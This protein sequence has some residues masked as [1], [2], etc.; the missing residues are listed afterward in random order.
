MFKAPKWRKLVWAGNDTHLCVEYPGPFQ[1]VHNPGHTCEAHLLRGFTQKYIPDD[2]G[3][4]TL[5]LQ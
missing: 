4:F 3:R 1:R 5:T 2:V